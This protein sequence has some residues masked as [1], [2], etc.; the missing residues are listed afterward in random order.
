MRIRYYIFRL[1]TGG[2]NGVVGE[3]FENQEFRSGSGL[4]G[5]ETEFLRIEKAKNIKR[6]RKWGGFKYFTPAESEE[7]IRAPLNSTPRNCDLSRLFNLAVHYRLRS[8]QGLQVTIRS[9]LFVLVVA[10]LSIPG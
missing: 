4:C 7:V 8:Y 6:P 2:G 3:G 9:D 1:R 5:R 10:N